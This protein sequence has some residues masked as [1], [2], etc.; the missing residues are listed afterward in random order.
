MPSQ[1][2]APYCHGMLVIVKEDMDLATE[3]RMTRIDQ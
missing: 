3:R 2:S 1:W